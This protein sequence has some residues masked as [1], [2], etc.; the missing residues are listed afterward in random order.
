[1]ERLRRHV[2]IDKKKKERKMI[3]HNREQTIRCLFEGRIYSYIKYRCEELI[4]MWYRN[5][6][7][8]VNSTKEKLCYKQL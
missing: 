4:K 8:Y 5:N 1:M 7:N 6:N 2:I 3:E